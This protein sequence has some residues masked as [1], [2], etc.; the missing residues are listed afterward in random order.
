M[1]PPSDTGL[2]VQVMVPPAAGAGEGVTV[3]DGGAWRTLRMSLFPLAL[4]SKS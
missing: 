1:A 2:G 3:Y 4:N